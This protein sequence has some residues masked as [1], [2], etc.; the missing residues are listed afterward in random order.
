[1]IQICYKVNN[2]IFNEDELVSV[3]WQ[4][5]FSDKT[6]DYVGRIIPS[7][8]TGELRLDVSTMYHSKIIDICIKEI[9]GIHEVGGVN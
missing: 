7:T 8:L 1:M 6:V 4:D 9:I 3:K 2:R 5:P